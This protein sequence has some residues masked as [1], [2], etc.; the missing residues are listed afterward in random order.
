MSHL[1]A[2]SL[3]WFM[4][5]T[6]QVPGSTALYSITISITSHIHSWALFPFCSDVSSFFL[7]LF[8]HSSPVAYWAPANLGSS[9]FCIIRFYLFILFMGFSGQEHWSGLPVPSL[10]DHVLS[11]LSTMT[12]SSWVA[13]HSMAHS[14]I[15]LEKANMLSRFVIVSLPRSRCLSRN[16]SRPRNGNSNEPA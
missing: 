5:L 16:R 6:F 4:N 15:E 13:L 8:L 9:S 11:E 1:T 14:F 12:R 7:E 10:V 3:P 2:F